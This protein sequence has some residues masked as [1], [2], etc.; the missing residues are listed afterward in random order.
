MC[1]CGNSRLV[2]GLWTWSVFRMCKLSTSLARA[3]WAPAPPARPAKGRVG[4]WG[5]PGLT[6]H[7]LALPDWKAPAL[8]IAVLADPH[9]CRPW[10]S[11]ERIAQ[12]VDYTNT[13]DADLIV[14]A[15]DLLPDRKMM[16]D[17]LVADK[18]VPLFKPL[19]APLG[20]H[21]IMGN[22]DREDCPQDRAS[23]GQVNSIIQAFADNDMPLVRNDAVELAHSG[24]PFWLVSLDTQRGRGK[25]RMGYADAEAAF[26]KVPQGAPSILL[27]HEPDYFA[28]GDPRPMLQISGHTHGGQFTVF[29]RRPATPSR[30]GDRYAIGHIVEEERHL[31]VSAGLGYSGFPFRFGVPPEITLIEVF[32]PMDPRGNS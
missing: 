21:A 16:C 24:C 18:I 5:L 1:L 27:A 10:V 25:R 11:P 4:L 30:Y 13:L 9:V 7:R 29:G 6:L 8:R 22:H 12:I 23:K 32:S 3:P 26:S 31:I 28:A 2:A 14:L 15:G 20:V 19:T 17:H